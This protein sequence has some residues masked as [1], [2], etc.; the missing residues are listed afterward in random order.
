[1]NNQLSN[2]AVQYRKFSKG[3]YIEYTQFNEFLDFFEDQ[4]RLSRVM[5][6]GVGIVCGLKPNLVYTNRVLSGIQLSQG[7]ALTTDGDL[8]TLNNTSEVNKDLYVSDLKTINIQNKNYTHFKTYDN[9]KVKYPSFHDKNGEGNQVELWELATA[10]EASLDFQTINN[11]PNLEDKYLLLYLEDYEKEVKPC[12]GVDCDN[13]GIQQIRNLKVLVT[14]KIGITNILGEERLIINPI[15]GEARRSIKDRIQP[16]PLFLEDILKAEKPERVIVERLI[17]D[18]PDKEFSPEDLNA[19]Y[20]NALEKHGYG[21]FIFKKINAISAIIGAHTV[22]HQAFKNALVNILDQKIGFQYAY[23]VVKDL[24]DTYSEIIKLLPKSFTKGFPD[25]DSFPK[26]I[27]LGKLVSDIQLDEFRHRFYNSPVL[28]DEKATQKVRV[29]IDRFN[30]QI[31]NFKYLGPEEGANIKITPSQKLNPLSNK[32][33]PFYYQVTNDFLKAWNFDKTSN[34]SSGDNLRYDTDLVSSDVYVKEPLDFNIDKNSFYNIEGH[35]GMPYETAFEQIKEIRDKHQLGFDIMVLSFGELSE[36]K[37]L[38]KA[39]FNEYVEKHPGLE[40]KRGVER[41]GTFVMVYEINGRNTNVVADF[42]LPYICCTPKIEASLSLPST[43]ICA[44]ADRMPFTVL[45]VGGVIKANVD[46]VR[47]GVEVVG[48]KYFFNPKLVDTSL[49]G[50]VINFTVN[51]KPVSFGIKVT[52][53]PKVLINVSRVDYPEGLSGATKVYLVIDDENFKDY[54]YSWDFWDNGSYI[55]LNPDAEGRVNFT[56][57]NLDPKRVPT[58]KVKVS[59]SGCTQ[60]VVVRDWYEAPKVELFLGDS[61]ICSDYSAI[62]FIVS[63][64]GGIVTASDGDGVQFVNGKYVFDPT[65]VDESLYGQTITFKVDGQQTDCSI[66]VIAKPNVTVAL[67]SVNYPNGSS[68]EATVYFK[69]S[70]PGFS[71]YTYAVNGTPVSLVQPGEEWNLSYTFTN[72]NPENI[73]AIKVTITNGGCIQTVEISKWYNPP[74]ASVNIKDVRFSDTNCCQ[75]PIPTV[76]VKATGPGKASKRENIF[77]LSGE[78]DGPS[79]LIYSWEQ[80]KGPIAKLTGVNDLDLV[81]EDLMIDEYE[82]Q[83]TAL[84]V[85]SGVF[86]K[87]EKLFIIVGS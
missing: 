21:E 41:G 85:A 37:D 35:Q 5:L 51:D 25:L 53:E 3:Q 32:A 60:E 62:D 14:S 58:I 34:R 59:S 46:L 65:K 45:P 78:A 28:D 63:P 4:D 33:I 43:V 50:K 55:T 13:H 19:L 77:K 10:E 81:V 6:Q 20:K 49:Y 73:P 40:H 16:H 68:T 42:S 83:L 11:L 24:M 75:Y 27:M 15:T 70:G 1:M 86:A 80:L 17:L 74:R 23:D 44:E 36:N 7:V 8:L 61:V 79:S 84:D 9:F 39:Y 22:D 66:K 29:L 69:V 2:I 87:S 82:F 67:H 76:T 12:R 26:H 31:Q 54:T 47:N 30:Q 18:K 57:I 64:A 38:S 52:E 71:T 72:L 56:Y 48:G